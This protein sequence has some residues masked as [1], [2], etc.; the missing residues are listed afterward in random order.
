MGWNRPCFF[1]SFLFLLQT[2]KSF[3]ELS[4]PSPVIVSRS[5]LHFLR[6]IEGVFLFFLSPPP[7]LFSPELL[8]SFFFSSLRLA[9]LDCTASL[10]HH[11]TLDRRLLRL[12]WLGGRVDMHARQ[13]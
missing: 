10:H 11:Q 13:R 8:G 2:K 5:S 3:I 12:L 6:R 4:G 9:C 1:V 7:P